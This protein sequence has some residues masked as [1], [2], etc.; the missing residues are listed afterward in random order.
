M[1]TSILRTTIFLVIATIAVCSG[2]T[3]HSSESGVEAT[4]RAATQPLSADKTISAVQALS[5][6][7]VLVN[8]RYQGGRFWTETRKDKLERFKCSQCHNDQIVSEA[9]A[10]KVA[11][12]DIRLVHGSGEK[13]LSCYTCHHQ[14]E[15][16][17]LNSET[18]DKLDMD[19]SYALCGQ[20]HFRQHKDWVGGAHGKRLTY[21]AGSRVVTNCTS[22][23]NP[24][25]PR[26]QKRWPVTYS[27]P[28]GK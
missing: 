6:P 2:W 17:F 18:E 11:H 21:W 28:K 12:G 25:A 3:A 7:V 14:E 24:H 27:P 13:Q 10:A 9:N 1:N 19:H 20:C 26:F 15:R 5:E 4:I 16:D 23:H 8:T 22:C